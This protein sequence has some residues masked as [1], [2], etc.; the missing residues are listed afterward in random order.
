MVIRASAAAEVTAAIIYSSNAYVGSLLYAERMNSQEPVQLVW[1]GSFVA[2]ADHGSF[3]AAARALTRSQPRVSAHIAALENQLGTRLFERTSRTVRLTAA[4]ATF[5][6]HARTV[7]RGLRT[8]VEAVGAAAATLQGRVRIGSYPGA[9]AVIMAPLVK[10]FA[11]AHP[12]AS[13]ELY[14]ADPSA[15]EEAVVNREVDFAVRTVDVPQRHH[16]LPSR[17]LFHEKIRLVLRQDHPLAR[18]QYPDPSA[19]AEETVIVSG[20]GGWIDYQDRL[21]RLG[22]EPR[23]LVCVVQPTTMVA[24]VREGH[25]VGLLGALAA[26]VTVSGEELTTRAL[27]APLWLREIRCYQLED[28]EATPVVRAFLE[29]LHREAPPL[30]ADAAV[31]AE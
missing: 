17:T 6:P 31:W 1:L 8:G 2:V 13:V 28:V 21:D 24:L 20:G 10:R 16:R 4:G 27:P 12:G 29:L 22:V 9:M 7:L 14:E 5:L 23:G 19:L 3:T 18:E 26:Q 30:T 11:T 25:G 15:L